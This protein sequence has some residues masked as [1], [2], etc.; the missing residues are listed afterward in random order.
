[1]DVVWKAAA[2]ALTAAILG[3]LIRQ[4]NPELAL[5]LSVCTVTVILLGTI[6]LLS[7]LVTLFETAESIMSRSETMVAPLFKCC[8]IGLLSKICMEL[9]AEAG[10]HAAAVAVELAGTICALRLVLPLMISVLKLIGGMV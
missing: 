7:G 8:A 3:L 2:V 4:K 1:M 9:C 10:N 5:L 6:G